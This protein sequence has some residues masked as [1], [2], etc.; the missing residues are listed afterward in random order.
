MSHN[1]SSRRATPSC[2]ASGA[3]YDAIVI[4]AG[5]GGLY[6]THRLRDEMGLRVKG[7]EA[8][9]GVGGTWYWNCYPGA[10]TDSPYTAYRYSWSEDLVRDWTWSERY[11]S[12]PEVLRYLEFVA[13]RLD[14]RRS[15][16]FDARVTAADYD[17]HE[18]LW[19]VRV[20]DG[21][22][23]TTTFLISALG[24]VSAPMTPRIDGLNSFDGAVIHASTWPQ[25]AHDFSGQKVALIGT[26]ST[27]IQILP[28]LAEQADEVTVFQR[29]PNYVVPAQN[30]SLTAQ[31]VDDLQRRHRDIA[32]QLRCHPFALPMA[33]VGM[34][35]LDVDEA[36]RARVYEEAWNKGGFHFLFETFDDI[37][38]NDQA[39]E[40]ACEFIRE[41]IRSIVKD[42]L[43]AKRLT[44]KGYPYGAKRP[45]AGTG[46]YEAY[47]RPNVN[48]VDLT[49]E[50]IEG[51]TNSG[52]RTAG[53][54]YDLDTIILATGFDAATGSFTRIDIRGRQGI[55]LAEKWRSGP[56]T[57][58]GFATAGF[59]NLL[60]VTG[61]LS[62]FANLPTCIEETVDWIIDLIG[63][64]TR[65][66]LRAVEA[67]ESGEKEWADQV[68]SAANAMTAAKGVAVQS[69]FT[70]ANVEGKAHAVNV[71]FGGA[72]TY[73]DLCSTS[74]RNGYEGFALR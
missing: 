67:T 74:A 12:Q 55:S 48:L 16:N 17:E 23:F 14:V 8:A 46:Y 61:P 11:P 3:E 19:R 42:P 15:Y 7:L 49:V 59:P 5:M 24:L 40:T 52:I 34:N 51:V 70:G 32:K 9:P 54:Y 27:G 1:S 2:S 18:N 6:A 31:E 63:H 56:L 4:G 62:P 47:N 69:W 66:G 72:N 36:T 22:I 45:P 58:L 38:V 65:H 13:D 37:A 21:T 20:E 43:T 50:P 64:M 41:K 71:Y 29:T 30:R 73:F 35:A 26:G 39:N 10:R 28:I 53:G 33:T 25:E 57:S 60:M 68:T 44:P